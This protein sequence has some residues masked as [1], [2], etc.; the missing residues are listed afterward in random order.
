MLTQIQKAVGRLAAHQGFRRYFANTS[1]MFGEQILR[2]VAGLLVGIYVARYLGPH[3]FGIYSYALAFV[4]PFNAIARMGVDS[5][6]LRD[7]LNHPEFSD[8][9][10]GTAFWLKLV[11]ALSALSVLAIVTQLINNDA[12]TNL[13]IFIIAS[14][15]IFHSFDVV[16]FHFQSRVLSK[17]VALCKLVQLVLSSML[18]LYFILIQAD[19]LSFVLVSLF[20]QI[21]LAMSLAFAYWRQK[22]G[23]FFGKFNLATAK[24]MLRNSWPLFL[25]GI[26]TTLYMR[27][28]QIMIKEMLGER[29]VGLYSAAVRISEAWYFVPII[30]TASL[31]PAVVNAKRISRTLYRRRL[32][33]LYTL[34]TWLAISVALSVTFL[35]DWIM[36][37]LY[38]TSYKESGV[39]LSIHI[40]TGVFVGLGVAT[41]RLMINEN[42]V[43]TSML[44]A[45]AGMVLNVLFN[46][47]LIPIYGIYGSAIANLFSQIF[48]A[49]VFDLFSLRTRKLFVMKSKSLFLYKVFV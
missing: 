17:Y 39:V 49:Y 33:R 45:M 25:T 26:A 32:Q 20:D 3:Q 4:A 18:K 38:G 28:D 13:Y 37:L 42:L 46:F 48:S 30:I 47:F 14:G 10:L 12:R 31:F 11:G 36:T 6:V 29:E 34:I 16:D 19:L 40:W 43:K 15:L 1:W 41:E 7:L 21:S 27:I 44:R 5:I 24:A 35:G 8:I 2:I 23:S 9:Y 22:I